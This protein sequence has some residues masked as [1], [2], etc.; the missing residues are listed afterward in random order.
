MWPHRDGRINLYTVLARLFDFQTSE[1]D[2]GPKPV[3]SLEVIDNRSPNEAPRY[4]VTCRT[5]P[6]LLTRN[7]GFPSRL[8][9]R[10][11]N[12]NRRGPPTIMATP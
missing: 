3:H 4:I 6:A 5:T 7:T 1:A 11:S 9:E 8:A 10:S 12:E 2:R